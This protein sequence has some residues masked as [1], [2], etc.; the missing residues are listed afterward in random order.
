MERT[1]TATPEG[2]ALD[3]LIRALR[4]TAPLARWMSA[5]GMGVFM[6]MV[7]LTF[8]DVFLRYVFGSSFNGT[9][10]VTELL[11]VIVVFSSIA[12]TQWQKSHVTMDILTAKLR[13]RP[14]ALLGTATALWSLVTIVICAYTTARYAHSTS[15]VTLVLR[16]PLAPFI[17]LTTFGFI[18]LA[19]ALLHDLLENFAESCALAGARQAGLALGLALLPVLGACWLATHKIPGASSIIIGVSGLVCLFIMFFLGMPVAFALMAT[20]LIFMGN[21]RG[22]NASFTTVGKGLYSTASSYAWSPLMFFMLMGYLCFHARFG[23][24]IYD[25]ARKW[26][27]HFRGGLALGSVAACALFGAVVGDVLSGSIAMAAI[28]L[29]EMRKHGYDDQLAVGTLTCSGTIGCLIPPS[30]T[31]IIYGVLAQQSIGDMFIAGIIPGLICMFCFMLVVWL[32]VL[33]KP[34]LAPRLPRAAM[35]ERMLSLKSGLPILCIFVLV[36]GGIYGGVFTATEGGGIG[37]FG[38]LLLALLMRRLNRRNFLAA[39]QDSAKF[40]SMCFTV[41]C[42]AIVLSY[43]MAMT[44]IPMVLANTI[45]ALDVA[46]LL[47]LAAIILVFCVLGCFL[48]SMPLLLICVP[49]FVPIA[50][51][52]GWNLIWFGIIITVLDNMASITPPFGINLFVMKE[53]TGIRLGAMYRSA[54]PFVLALF[55]CLGVVIAFP[56]LSTYLP[57]LMRK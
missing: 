35:R 48:P 56:A 4:A 21:I 31:F 20:G 25:C 34:S 38:T 54:A 50:K 19:L 18:T 39:L 2:L 55:I 5:T 11:M 42:G 17:Y 40:I 10:E 44:R 26:L 8:I 1:Q 28:A 57:D 24:D 51:V 30:T 13:E 22:L 6:I 14:R 15:S 7:F 12:Y 45:A 53:V 9:V 33:R 52:Y 16:I 23:E 47:V 3:K 27:G 32:L 41:L 49:I 29:P 37:A 43:F 46:P 36:I